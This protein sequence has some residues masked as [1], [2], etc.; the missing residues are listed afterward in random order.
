VGVQWLHSLCLFGIW[1]NYF[2][3]KI[4]EIHKVCNQIWPFF[5]SFYC[6][7]EETELSALAFTPPYKIL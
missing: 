7:E 4:F 2:C 1:L 3:W 6:D 5:A